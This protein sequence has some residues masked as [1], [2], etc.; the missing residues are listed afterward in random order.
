MTIFN[1]APTL[2]EI[3]EKT[4][5]IYN[6]L[7]QKDKVDWM[8]SFIPQPKV[9]QTYAAA[10]GGNSLGLADVKDD[11][12]GKSPISQTLSRAHI[13]TRLHSD[14]VDFPMDRP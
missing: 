5:V 10:T 11:Q 3:W 1:D 2:Q 14:L 4:D 12:I 6:A 8:V 9:Q 7:P 13:L